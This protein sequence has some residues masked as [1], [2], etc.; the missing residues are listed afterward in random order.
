MNKMYKNPTKT[1]K[2]SLVL[3]EIEKDFN[4]ELKSTSEIYVVF[5]GNYEILYEGDF[6][7]CYIYEKYFKRSNGFGL[8]IYSKEKFNQLK[9]VM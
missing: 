3:K 4:N 8:L 2:D 6:A 1:V 9:N 7:H 5:N